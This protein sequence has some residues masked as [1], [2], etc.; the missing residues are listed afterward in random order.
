MTDIVDLLQPGWGAREFRSLRASRPRLE[1]SAPVE[2]TRRRPD[3]AV[4]TAIVSLSLGYATL[5]Y[6]VLKGVSWADWPAYT[7]NKAIAVAA[8]LLIVVA[9]SRLMQRMGGIGK[10]LA[11]AG[12]FAL[13]HSLLSFALF[14]PAYYAR[15]FEGGKLTLLGGASM[16]LGAAAMA[17]M[18]L[19]ARR[20][21]KWTRAQKGKGLALI[22]SIGGLHAALS[23]VPT[24]LEPG[25]WPGAMPPLTLISFVVGAWGAGLWWRSRR[26]IKRVD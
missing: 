8:L 6:N 22:A 26:H 3:A 4:V 19:G 10:L 5:R 7:L 20:S 15:L 13:M 18:E 12:V 21:G 23:A 25:T 17:A 2:P 1:G 24:W 16:A 9:I 14:S 11:L